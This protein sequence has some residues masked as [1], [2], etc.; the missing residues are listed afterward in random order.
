MTAAADIHYEGSRSVVKALYL[1]ADPSWVDAA[2]SGSVTLVVAPQSTRGDLL[3]TLFWNRSVERLVLLDDAT[4]PDPFAA[5]PANVDDAGHLVGTTGLVLADTH[6]SS[7]VLRNAV[8]VAAGPTKTLWRPRGVPQ[9]ELLMTGRF[10]SG[11][12]SGEGAI[13]VWPEH[14]GGKLEGWLELDLSTPGGAAA[15]PFRVELPSGRSVEHRIPAGRITTIRVPVCAAG[16]WTAPFTAGT[17]ALVHGTLVGLSSSE[18]RFV[19]GA[20]ACPSGAVS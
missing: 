2:G 14:A 9:L 18:P 11:G 10:F 13:R 15:L 12:L 16:V 7:L 1:P 3:T 6:G 17:D 8:R 5:P 20:A 4:A 19:A